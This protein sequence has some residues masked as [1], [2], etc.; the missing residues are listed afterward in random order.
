MPSS[1][2]S[3]LSHCHEMPSHL[4]VLP[5]HHTR[6]RTHCHARARARTYAVPGFC[7]AGDGGGGS[8]PPNLAG[9]AKCRMGRRCGPT[10]G[11]CEHPCFTLK[12]PCHPAADCDGLIYWSGAVCIAGHTTARP[13]AAHTRARTASHDPSGRRLQLHSTSA[14]VLLRHAIE[15]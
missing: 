2:V 6:A 12:T 3:V 5:V 8:D 10:L 15:A 1:V 13:P 11:V 14:S 7:R 9:F 4:P